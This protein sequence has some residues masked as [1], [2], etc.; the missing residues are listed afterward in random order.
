MP[1]PRT[2]GTGNI[3]APGW[4]ECGTNLRQGSS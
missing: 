1:V 3:L 4:D 2:L